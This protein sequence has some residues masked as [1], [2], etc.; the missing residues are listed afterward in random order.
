MAKQAAAQEACPC[1]VLQISFAANRPHLRTRASFRMLGRRG[2]S[3]RLLARTICPE[4]LLVQA[5]VSWS[6]HS[7]WIE[8]APSVHRGADVAAKKISGE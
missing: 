2:L 4:S 7:F 6:R 5:D 1:P 8:F 3:R